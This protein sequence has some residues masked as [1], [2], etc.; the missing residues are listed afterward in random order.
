[1]VSDGTNLT[2]LTFA[3]AGTYA[4]APN[5]QLTNTDSNDHDVTIWFALNGTAVTRSATRMTVPKATDGGNAFFQLL[6]YI[7]V[8]AGQ[9]V[10]VMW[11]PE[12]VNVT[13]DHTAMAGSVPAIPSAIVI[14]ERIA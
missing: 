9:Y 11:L 2:R 14:A 12:H 7:T 5:L 3:A 10:Q 6:T 13:L 1:V 8:T 4:I